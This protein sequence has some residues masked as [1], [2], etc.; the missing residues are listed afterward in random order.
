M[1][2]SMKYT[3]NL[4]IALALTLSFSGSLQAAPDYADIKG[5]VGMT[6]DQVKEKFGLPDKAMDAIDPNR[7]GTWVYRKVIH[8]ESGK[9]VSCILL[10]TENGVYAVSCS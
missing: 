6:K 3:Q 8:P 1:E 7:R 5:S 10:F 4:L 2:T 9:P